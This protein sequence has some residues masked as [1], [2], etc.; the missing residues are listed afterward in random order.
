MATS[1]IIILV[2]LLIFPAVFA[3]IN[4]VFS[5][6]S[7][8]DI[9]NSR[10]DGYFKRFPGSVIEY[11]RNENDIQ[12]VVTSPPVLKDEKETLF[13]YIEISGNRRTVI[14]S[15]PLH[16]EPDPVYHY[17]LEEFRK[18]GFEIICSLK[19]EEQMG[20]PDKWIKQLFITDKNVTAWKDL[21]LIMKGDILCYISGK[22]NKGGKDIFAS[23]FSANH[24]RNDKRS[25]VF[26][27]ISSS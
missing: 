12:R 1:F 23:L 7:T 16:H 5:K 17:Y 20:R 15:I 10:S 18:A 27:F 25:A 14:Y 13:E 9:E 8:S 3:G 26:V 11:Y 19:G 4:N 21:A 22:K 6:K 2:I 24:Y